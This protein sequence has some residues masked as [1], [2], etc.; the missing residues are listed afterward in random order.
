MRFEIIYQPKDL[1]YA[2]FQQ[3]EQR[4]FPEDPINGERFAEM[5]SEGFWGV[6]S[7]NRFIG[8]GYL[9]LKPDAAWIYRIAVS[10]EF[11]RKGVGKAL[12]KL[13]VDQ[14]TQH[15]REKIF[16]RVLK[17][18]QAAFSLYE[19]FN[20]KAI[21]SLSQFIVPIRTFLSDYGK[22]T[23]RSITT[24]PITE[25]NVSSIPFIPSE[26]SDILQQHNPPRNYVLLFRD[27]ENKVRGF[28]RLNP[29]F[30]GCFP[31]IIDDPSSL[32]AEAILALRG[33]LNPEKDIL[34]ITTADKNLIAVCHQLGFR[35]YQEALRMERTNVL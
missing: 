30:P 3:V 34:K 13:L 24:T 9:V 12:M 15:K 21:D 10:E 20:F 17:T 1:T 29:A 19:T 26:W 31:L 11:R 14:S 25:Q 2:D 23:T 32:L 7:K 16:L 35:L 27:L 18:N 22:T 5:L 4:C 6:F 8:Y 28:C 33:Y